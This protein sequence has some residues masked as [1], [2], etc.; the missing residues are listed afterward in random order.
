MKI[1]VIV[2]RKNRLLLIYVQY[3]LKFFI[4]FDS[5]TGNVYFFLCRITRWVIAP[6]RSS[7]HRE[8]RVALCVSIIDWKVRRAELLLVE[9]E[10]QARPRR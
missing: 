3:R 10:F 5:P 9:F 8:Y 4:T 6:L 1:N 2:N 7:V